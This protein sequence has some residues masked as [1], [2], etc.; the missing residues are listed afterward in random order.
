[1]KARIVTVISVALLAAACRNDSKLERSQK[2]YEAVQEGS[3]AGVTSTIS[4]P[5]ETPPPVSSA[6]MTGTNAD[7]TTAFTLPAT[8][9]DSSGSMQQ[10]GSLAGTIPSYSPYPQTPASPRPRTA[11]PPRPRESHSDAPVATDTVAVTQTQSQQQPPATTTHEQQTPPPVT[12]TA[13]TTTTAP[14]PPPTSEHSAQPP[15]PP[16][17]STDTTSTKPPTR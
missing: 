9:T 7:T 15:T 12:D 13:A 6:P 14:P 8:A 2:S 1:M 10:P 3:A 16:P 17:P 5:G 4:G 11:T